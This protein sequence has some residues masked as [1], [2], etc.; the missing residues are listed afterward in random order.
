MTLL[1]SRELWRANV[2]PKVKFFFW[3]ALHGRLWTAERRKQHGHQPDATCALCDQMDETGDHLLC[4]CVYAREV[5][6]RLLATMASIA[7]PPQHDACLLGWWMSARE[8]VPQV[9]RWS[10]DSLVLLVTWDL[11]KERNR[12]TFDHRSAT[13]SELVAAILEEAAAWIG[14][15]YGSLALLTGLV[16]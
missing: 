2:P 5:R 3:L 4:S 1:G 11:W 13:P 10:F 16:A 12:R 15:G 8:D 14:A 6:S 7:T 9:L